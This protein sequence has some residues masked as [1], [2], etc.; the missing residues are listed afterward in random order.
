MRNFQY[1]YILLF[2]HLNIYNISSLE[3]G[4]LNV[5]NAESREIRLLDV[6]NSF[7][8]ISN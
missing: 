6:Y 2:I 5:N 1:L 3:L 4:E 7:Y 8:A